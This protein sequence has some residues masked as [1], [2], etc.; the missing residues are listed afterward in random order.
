MSRNAAQ[1]GIKVVREVASWIFIS[2]TE[3][4][5]CSGSTTRFRP[6]RMRMAGKLQP[7]EGSLH[8]CWV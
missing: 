2:S 6:H 5:N 4:T 1:P 8:R 7:F 3:L